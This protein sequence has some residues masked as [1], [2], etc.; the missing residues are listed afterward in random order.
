MNYAQ[1]A[2]MS[3]YY[4]FLGYWLESDDFPRL[5]FTLEDGLLAYGGSY[6][7]DCFL[8]AYK[9]GIFPWPSGDEE[10]DEF[11]NPL[12]PWFSPLHRFVLEPE[13]LHVSHSL[14]KTIRKGKFTVCTDRNFEAVIRHCANVPRAEGGT[15]ITEGIIQTFCEL[16]RLGYAH[17]VECY[18]GDDLVGGFYGTQIGEVFGGESMFTLVPDASKVAFVTFVRQAAERGIRLIDCQCYTDNMARYGAHHMERAEFLSYL[19]KV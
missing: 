7:A 1:G 14:E 6:D 3:F 5:E 13:N 2:A 4:N 10:L 16:H 17:S 11:G 15:W 19:P 12:I 8:R 9:L 18:L